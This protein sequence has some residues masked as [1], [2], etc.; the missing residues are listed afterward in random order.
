M[1]H[2][3]HMRWNQLLDCSRFFVSDVTLFG[4]HCSNPNTDSRFRTAASTWW[5]RS[6]PVFS[7]DF[8]CNAISVPRVRLDGRRA[9]PILMLRAEEVSEATAP[10]QRRLQGSQ[11]V[12]HEALHRRNFANARLCCTRACMPDRGRQLRRLTVVCLASMAFVIGS[13]ATAWAF[14]D[15]SRTNSIAAVFA[16]NLRH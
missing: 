13:I 7:D 3:S 2:A 5:Q 6:S 4:P 12:D 9:I 11:P 10:G 1:C 14:R 8:V 16:R 15:V